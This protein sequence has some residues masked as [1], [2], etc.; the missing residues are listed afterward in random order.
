MDKMIDKDSFEVKLEQAKR[1]IQA[2][3]YISVEDA[4]LLAEAT[5]GA[6]AMAK[7]RERY[8]KIVAEQSA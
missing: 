7:I 3:K 4:R 5:E 1:I 6:A 2:M 8:Y